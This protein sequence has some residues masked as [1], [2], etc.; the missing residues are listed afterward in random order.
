MA[1]RRAA[2]TCWEG[3]WLDENE[4]ALVGTASS[5]APARVAAL[6]RLE[7]KTS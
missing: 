7:K 2:A 3:S 1:R 6:D 4:A 5:L